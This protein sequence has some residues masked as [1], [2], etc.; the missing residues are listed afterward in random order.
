MQVFSLHFSGNY[1]QIF[2]KTAENLNNIGRLG[3][4]L[5]NLR[6]GA[7]WQLL[8]HVFEFRHTSW[9]DDPEVVETMHRHR[10]TMACSHFV[11]ET[12]RAGDMETGWHFSSEPHEEHAIPADDF[13]YVRCLGT[14]GRSIGSYSNSQLCELAKQVRS[15]LSAMVVF[16]QG[17]APPQAIEN[18][19]KLHTIIE[20][21]ATAPS[22]DELAED[23]KTQEVVTG[24]VVASV[25]RGWNRHAVVDVDGRRGYLGYR[26]LQKQGLD[27]KVGT[28]LE[29]LHVEADNGRCLFLSAPELV[30][31]AA[32]RAGGA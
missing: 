17:D 21:G 1:L 2:T 9:F 30:H 18:A 19:T 7:R 12:G 23:K 31:H 28:V 25:T 11:N 14:D 32:A 16:G 6:H 13:L 26:H 27:L 29:D 4:Q 10:L 15:F 5:R 20:S 8:H 24:T 22:P 3:A